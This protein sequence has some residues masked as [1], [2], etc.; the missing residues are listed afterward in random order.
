MCYLLARHPEI[1]ER[2]REEV[3]ANLPDPTDPD[4]AGDVDIA[5]I[6]DSLPLLNG[7]CQ[8]TLRL[9]PTVPITIRIA[10][11]NTSLCGTP[12]P[13]LTQIMLCPWATN[14][15]PHLWGDNAEEFVPERWIDPDTQKPNN[16]GG[17]PSN[18]AILTF[19]HGPR[20]CIGQGFAKAELKALVAV[21][22]G[23]FDIQMKDPSEDV[24]PAGVITTKP[25]NGMNLRL[26]RLGDW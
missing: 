9:Y 11:R 25:K 13:R 5:S 19:L 7:V 12:I 21:F 26:R 24:I 17:A 14:R 6:L 20:S 18:Y 15:S 23:R 3:K 16:T 4:L 10:R 2:L 8:E 22:V 1:Q